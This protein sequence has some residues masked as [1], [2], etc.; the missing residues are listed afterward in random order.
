LLK[1]SF[2]LKPIQGRTDLFYPDLDLNISKILPTALTLF[3]E[4]YPKD[5]LLMDYF[6]KKESWKK[7][8]EEEISNIVFIILDS[9][10]IDQFLSYSKLMNQNFESNGLALSSVFPTITSSCIASLRFGE[11]PIKHGIVGQKIRFA[12]IDSVVDTLTLRTKTSSTDL[13]S[14]GINVKNWLWCDFLVANDPSI[15]HVGLIDFHI[16]N[17]GLSHLV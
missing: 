10:G 13:Q 7:L 5:K 8:Q 17:S 12:E 16:A 14:M 2:P 15:S 11:M 3:G 9:L 6:S 4:K 1:E